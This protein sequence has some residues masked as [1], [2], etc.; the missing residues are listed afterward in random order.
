[1]GEQLSRVLHHDTQQ[2]I[3]TESKTSIGSLAILGN[4][5]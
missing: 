4:L 3:F 1:M 2:L 5:Y